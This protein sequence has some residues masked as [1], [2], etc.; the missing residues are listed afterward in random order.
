MRLVIWSG[1]GAA[2]DLPLF[3]ASFSSDK[4]I[5]ISRCSGGLGRICGVLA[6]CVRVGAPNISARFE[7]NFSAISESSFVVWLPSLKYV[8]FL[9]VDS[10]LF[11]LF[12]AFQCL[13][14]DGL[15]DSR[16]YLDHVNKS[17]RAFI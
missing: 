16:D 11:N 5:D 1:P 14:V 2:D 17:N 13:E 8:D 10:R 12:S 15:K 3:I 7:A 6:C 9:F 4:L